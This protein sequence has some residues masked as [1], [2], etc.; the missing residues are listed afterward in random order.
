LKEI[1]LFSRKQE[2]SMMLIVPA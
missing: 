1:L 2:L